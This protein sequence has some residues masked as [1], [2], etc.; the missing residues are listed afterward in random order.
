MSIKKL[1]PYRI[2]RTLG[3]G[4]MGTVYAGTDERTGE[5]AAI[6]VLAAAL[7]TDETF[8]E[9]FESEIETLKTLKHPN[10]VQLYGYGEQD[11]HLFFAME[12][13]EGTSL[14]EELQNGRRFDWRATT[15]LGISICRALKHAHDSGVIHR[16]LKPA[17]LLI[18]GDEQIKLTDFG[19]AKLFGFSPLTADGGVLGTADY[20]APE[21]AQGDPVTPRSDLYSLGSVLFAL[22]AGRPP[23]RGKSLTDVLHMLRYAEPTPVCNYAPDVPK[24]LDRVIG[25][26]L[27][28]DPQKRIPTALALAN[29]LQATKHA[30]SIRATDTRPPADGSRQNEEF[31]V[32]AETI[33]DLKP[34]EID[35][36]KATRTNVTEIDSGNPLD[37]IGHP[38]SDRSEVELE[39]EV[40]DTTQPPTGSMSHFTTVDRDQQGPEGSLYA[41]DSDVGAWWV[42]WVLAAAILASIGSAVWFAM[43]PPSADSLFARIQAGANRGDVAVLGDVE[44]HLRRFLDL[45]PDDIRSEQVKHWLNEVELDRLKSRFKSRL[46]QRRSLGSL[47]P[48][49]S[50]CLQAIEIAKTNPHKAA[51]QL[52]AL[53]HVYGD[54]SH[55]SLQVEACLDLARRQ[56]AQLQFSLASSIGRNQKLIAQRLDHADELRVSDPVAATAICRGVIELYGDKPWASELVARA[57]RSLAEMERPEQDDD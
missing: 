22:L 24:E 44:D 49:E 28:K 52:Q 23:F 14:E 50:A 5:G 32:S 56:L 12:L 42:R 30:L 18:D 53:V 9:R 2:N 46:R 34:G 8:R 25:Q 45:F 10:I 21:Q 3:R 4:G 6:K 41:P 36:I 11:G 57:N 26:L 51:T 13:I 31:I 43:R 48:W 20:M 37:A 39:P 40:A 54:H 33:A 16:D 55:P 27:M 17:N 29:V 1:G 15:D 47:A 7:A 35:S 38:E 19:I